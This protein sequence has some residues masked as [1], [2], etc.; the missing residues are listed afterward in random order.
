[1]QTAQ[2]N[3]WLSQMA[4]RSAAQSEDLSEKEKNLK[5]A[6]CEHAIKKDTEYIA[7]LEKELALADEEIKRIP[8]YG[9]CES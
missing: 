3:I 4:S 9:L 8:D 7:F 6:S 1:M 2:E 5:I